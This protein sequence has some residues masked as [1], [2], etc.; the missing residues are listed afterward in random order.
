MLCNCCCHHRSSWSSS[1]LLSWYSK[2]AVFIVW[3]KDNILIT[4]NSRL[5]CL[6][7]QLLCLLSALLL[8]LLIFLQA[9]NIVIFGIVDYYKDWLNSQSYVEGIS[10]KPHVITT[11]VEHDAVMLPIRHLE[12]KG[13][14]G[15]MSIQFSSIQ[16]ISTIQ[17]L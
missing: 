12:K 9:N 1:S 16:F 17:P 13:A 7:V 8:T 15:N 3:P 2:W 11:N 4:Q 10:E 14:I 6:P 5:G